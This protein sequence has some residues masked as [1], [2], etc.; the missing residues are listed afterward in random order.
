MTRPLSFH[1]APS[2]LHLG[3]RGVYFRMTGLKNRQ[4]DNE[5]DRV[6]SASIEAILASLSP[7]FIEHDAELRGFR[8]LHEAIK[9]SNKSNVAS[10]ENLL[11][12]LLRRKALPRINLLVD[13]YNLVSLESRLAIGAH[14]IAKIVGDVSLRLTDGSEKFWPLGAAENKTISQGEY[15]YIDSS[16]DMICRLEVRQVEK[17]KVELSSTD[18]FYIV[19]GSSA[20]ESGVL[21]RTRERLALLTQKFCGGE[22]E[23]LHSALV[24]MSP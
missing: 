20:T 23:V 18:C 1:I 19:Q 9:R 3:V 10:P 15:A 4:S 7:E 2:V 6:W 13:I 14:D 17:T 11:N 12:L 21:D 8:S 22:M 16:N 24:A 5:F